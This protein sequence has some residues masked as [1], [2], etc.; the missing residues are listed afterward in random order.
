[1]SGNTRGK[2]KERFEGVHKN[3]DWSIHHVAV[4]LT[5]IE[6]QLAQLDGFDGLRGDPAKEQAFFLKNDMYKGMRALG[7]S[8]V[9]LDELAQKIYQTF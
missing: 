1:M 9:T 7:E 2:L 4:S 5:L 3:L 8:L 6:N